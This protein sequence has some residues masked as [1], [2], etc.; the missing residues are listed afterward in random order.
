MFRHVFMAKVQQGVPD[1]EVEDLMAAWRQ[2]GELIDDVK[3]LSTGRNESSQDRTY[4]IVLI[5]D[6]DNRAAWERYMQHPVHVKVRTTLSAEVLDP[7]ARVSA[8]YTL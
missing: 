7:V 1:S 3:A 2:M 5:V 6:F 4:T 8:Q